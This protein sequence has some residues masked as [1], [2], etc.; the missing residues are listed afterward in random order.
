MEGASLD[1]RR[2]VACCRDEQSAG[3]PGSVRSLT[4]LHSHSCLASLK[5]LYEERSLAYLATMKIA[6]EG[7]CHGRL[8]DIYATL[9]QLEQKNNYTVDL[10]LVCGDFQAVRN[11]RDL[12]TM[13][14]PEKYR[15]LGTFHK[16]AFGL[17]ISRSFADLIFLDTTL[18]K[19][20]RLYSPSSLGVIT[21][22]QTICGSCKVN[23]INVYTLLV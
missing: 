21:K 6:V 12:H 4:S 7:C 18:E 11:H 2:R 16:Y 14:C 9:K 15:A 23:L 17:G 22:R 20:R 13:A 5:K 10:L 3:Y 1:A 8:D 19:L